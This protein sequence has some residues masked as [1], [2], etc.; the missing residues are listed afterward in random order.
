MPALL[1]TEFQARVVWLGR[2]QDRDASLQAR[3]ESTLVA[4]F[5]GIDGEAHSGATRLSCGRVKQL[6]PRGTDIKNTRQISIVSTEDLGE[7]AYQ[8]GM[9]EIHPEWLGASMVVA[10]IPDFTLI[11]PSSRLQA[12]DGTTLTVDM[13][14]HPCLLPA[15]EIESAAPGFGARFKAAAEQRRGVT[16]WVER[17]GTIRLGD[18]LRLFVPGQD[19][20]PHIQSVQTPS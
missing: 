2:V 14:N 17:E 20:W 1:K 19:P 12:N 3:S 5:S 18:Q 6:Y 16:A 15:R 13:E 7:I 11:P 10:G 9:P 4:R 8:M